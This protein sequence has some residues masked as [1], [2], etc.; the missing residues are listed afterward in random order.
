MLCFLHKKH[1][2]VDCLYTIFY[3]W[4]KFMIQVTPQEGSQRVKTV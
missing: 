1:F 4:I 2:H 3:F